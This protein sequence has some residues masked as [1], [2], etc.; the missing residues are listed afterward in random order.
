MQI[1]NGSGVPQAADP[2]NPGGGRHHDLTMYTPEE[3]ILAQVLQRARNTKRPAANSSL[4]HSHPK[5]G[6]LSASYQR[7][8]KLAK[9]HQG[10]VLTP[11]ITE[12]VPDESRPLSEA[13]PPSD[14]TIMSTFG[15]N[16]T[17][18][19]DPLQMA[20]RVPPRSSLSRPTRASAAASLSV[21]LSVSPAQHQNAAPDVSQI[22]T[23]SRPEAEQT[24]SSLSS[25]ELPNYVK[26]RPL[27]AACPPNGDRRAPVLFTDEEDAHLQGLRC[28][29]NM[30][31]VDIAKFLRRPNPAVCTNRL[32]N[33]ERKKLEGYSIAEPALPPQLPPRS[34]GVLRPKSRRWTAEEDQQLL[35]MRK[36]G[37]S[38]KDMVKTQFHVNQR[39]EDAYKS[40]LRL[41]D[42]KKSPYKRPGAT[43]AQMA[44]DQDEEDPVDEGIEDVDDEMA[45]VAAAAAAADDD[46]MEEEYD[47]GH[48]DDRE[49]DM[50]M[51]RSAGKLDNRFWTQESVQQLRDMW[52]AGRCLKDIANI[53]GNKSAGACK[54]KL[55][56]LEGT[57]KNPGHDDDEDYDR[58][59]D[60]SGHSPRRRPRSG[61]ERQPPESQTGSMWTAEEDQRL[62]QMYGNMTYQQISD[63][64]G[65]RT[66]FACQNRYLE[67]KKKGKAKGKGSTNPDESYDGYSPM[68]SSGPQNP[69]K[70]KVRSSSLR[71]SV[72]WTVK[73][74]QQLQD[75]REGGQSWDKIA[76]VLGNRSMFACKQRFFE[77]MK[78]GRLALKDARPQGHVEEDDKPHSWPKS[79]REF[80]SLRSQPIDDQSTELRL[81]SSS[82][83]PL[84]AGEQPH[85]QDPHSQKPHGQEARLQEPQVQG[86]P[87]PKPT[88][89]EAPTPQPQTTKPRIRLPSSAMGSA[90]KQGLQPQESQ[91]LPLPLPLRQLL[92][93]DASTTH[94]Q[95][96][97]PR[98]PLPSSRTV[99]RPTSR[100]EAQLTPLTLPDLPTGQHP[101]QAHNTPQKQS[102]QPADTEA[103]NQPSSAQRMT[104]SRGPQRNE[105]SE[106]KSK[107][108]VRVHGATAG[109]VGRPLISNGNPW[110]KAEEQTILE[111][112]RNGLNLPQIT[113]LL[114]GRTVAATSQHYALMKERGRVRADAV[115]LNV[116]AVGVP[117]AVQTSVEE[118]SAVAGEQHAED[119]NSGSKE[120][121]TDTRGGAV[122]GGQRSFQPTNL[123]RKRDSEDSAQDSLAE[124]VSGSLANGE[125]DY[126]SGNVAK[127]AKI[128]EN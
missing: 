53:L 4:R 73:E 99:H 116:S 80:G 8:I 88:P 10:N 38:W 69:G 13:H 46:D 67:L 61:P 127:Q 44:D 63:A 126:G 68:H 2:I 121:V 28:M 87:L 65:N 19:S 74:E 123:K 110:S 122:V 57:L 62:L 77:M 64:L 14:N 33:L 119:G 124:G 84:A 105:P 21:S 108:R 113:K 5:D 9:H 93:H 81:E 43:K 79:K 31:F 89:N 101:Q 37:V 70:R 83:H 16:P 96:A 58:D 11:V 102:T 109:F 103:Q 35:H 120:Q 24:E 59:D 72:S 71:T 98:T 85:P 30:K 50:S 29:A 56:R 97:K 18:S 15:G 32:L 75:L 54:Q 82:A 22:S 39:T 100:Q 45:D 76:A 6:I 25:S 66:R 47:D 40:R 118:P 106:S 114:D 60:K 125:S 51:P 41:L 7:A 48:S 92:H 3:M 104:R 17:T 26:E 115:A 55:L 42:A 111:G 112:K 78:A 95:P 90:T 107:S 91:L 34:K 20:P 52:K 86:P 23:P 1:V 36:M 128:G 12:Q 49:S 94:S 27:L 117:L